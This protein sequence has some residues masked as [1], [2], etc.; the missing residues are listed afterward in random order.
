[1]KLIKLCTAIIFILSIKTTIAQEG[2]VYVEVNGVKKNIKA[3][4]EKKIGASNG[5]KIK[6]YFKNESIYCG[7]D[8]LII[9]SE[10]IGG[11]MDGEVI[12]EKIYVG[13]GIDVSELFRGELRAVDFFVP[14]QFDC[15]G[16]SIEIGSKQKR[17]F[18]LMLRGHH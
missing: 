5:D 7:I 6:F 1:M 15:N 13:D 10:I 4:K 14:K 3:Q 9:H 8:T 11:T 16:A 12:D 17:S 18:R 2:A